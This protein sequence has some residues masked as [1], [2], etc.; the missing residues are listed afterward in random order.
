[1]ARLDGRA[2]P[3]AAL[4]RVLEIGCGTGLLLTQLAPHAERYVATDLSSESLAFVHRAIEGRPDFANVELFER[5]AERLDGFAPA[6]FDTVI[7]NSVVQYFP[8]REYLELVLTGALRLLARGG[9]LFVGDV[10]D[11]RLEP[12]FAASVVRHEAFRGERPAARGE[13]RAR[14]ERRIAQERRSS[15]LT[16]PSSRRWRRA[17]SALPAW[18]LAC[19]KRGRADNELTCFRYDVVV[20]IGGAEAGPARD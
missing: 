2:D 11:A 9:H 18:A 15:W 5:T 19:P 6:E 10:R 3:A 7:L 17:R 8:D 12:L 1:M 20:T 14:L 16:P 4:R 13:L